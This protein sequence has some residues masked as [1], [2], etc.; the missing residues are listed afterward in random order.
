[1]HVTSQNA[2]ATL[3]I[4][5]PQYAIVIWLPWNCNLGAVRKFWDK[6]SIETILNLNIFSTQ[7]RKGTEPSSVKIRNRPPWIN[8]IQHVSP[9]EFSSPGVYTRFTIVAAISSTYCGLFSCYS[10]ILPCPLIPM[11]SHVGPFPLPSTLPFFSEV[12]RDPRSTRRR[13]GEHC[14]GSASGLLPLFAA[15]PTSLDALALRPTKSL[16]ACLIIFTYFYS[17]R[18]ALVA[19]L[20]VWNLHALARNACTFAFAQ[21]NIL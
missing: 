19:A 4:Q 5:A 6:Q 1:M 3:G 9:K 7:F 15:S 14:L 20:C 21:A 18:C 10:L 8:T 17:I 16:Y 12:K 2:S 13:S 11:P